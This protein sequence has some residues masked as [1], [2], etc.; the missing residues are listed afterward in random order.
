MREGNSMLVHVSGYTR[1]RARRKVYRAAVRRTEARFPTPKRKRA[2]IH[3][4][5]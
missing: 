4:A 1:R 2:R 3:H 5:H